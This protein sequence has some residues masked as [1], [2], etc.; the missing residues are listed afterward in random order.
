V[1]ERGGGYQDRVDGQLD[2]LPPIDRATLPACGVR[3]RVCGS[4]LRHATR[5]FSGQMGQRLGTAT[6]CRHLDEIGARIALGAEHVRSLADCH[7]LECERL[8]LGVLAATREHLRFT[9][10]QSICV[11]ASSLVP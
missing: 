10:R 5:R 2:P 11:R 7:R 4:E 9:C 3:A 8:R 1:R 6:E